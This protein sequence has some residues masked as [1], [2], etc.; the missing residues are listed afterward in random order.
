MLSTGSQARLPFPYPP[1]YINHRRRDA[2]AVAGFIR[3]LQGE[4]ARRTQKKTVCSDGRPSRL[5]VQQV[6]KWGWIANRW[7]AASPYGYPR[8]LLSLLNEKRQEIPPY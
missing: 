2:H 3:A 5:F 1:P 4:V 7:A 6:L 8:P